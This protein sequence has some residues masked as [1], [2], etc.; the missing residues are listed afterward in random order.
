MVGVPA[1]F[2][3]TLGC[4]FVEGFDVVVNKSKSAAYRAPG[5]PQAEYAAEMVVN[6]LAEALGMDPI[7]LRLKPRATP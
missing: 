6:E 7:D 2:W 3:R 1:G 5:A 4:S